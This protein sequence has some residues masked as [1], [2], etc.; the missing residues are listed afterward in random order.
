MTAVPKSLEAV[1][2]QT[3]YL[4]GVVESSSQKIAASCWMAAEA[5]EGPAVEFVGPM[6]VVV[7][8]VALDPR[9]S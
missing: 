7:V 1:F 5:A 8:G 9:H 4:L 2:E 6:K 3:N